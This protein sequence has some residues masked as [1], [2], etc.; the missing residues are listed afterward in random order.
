MKTSSVYF[1]ILYLKVGPIIF[2]DIVQNCKFVGHDI[3]SISNERVYQKFA[4]LFAGAAV[5]EFKSCLELPK[6]QIS[7][8]L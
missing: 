1:E 3:F 4:V 8:L 6:C 2:N 7:E 5:A